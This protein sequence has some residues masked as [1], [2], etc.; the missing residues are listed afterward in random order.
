MIFGI[1][2]ATCVC[3]RK[4][5]D[6]GQLLVVNKLDQQDL[7]LNDT[8]SMGRV[9]LNL[10]VRW[11]RYRGWMPEQEQIAFSI[12]PVSVP[13]QTFA[14]RDFFVWNNF[15]PRIGLT[16]D[17][18]NDGKTVIKAS[19]GLF[20]HNPGPGVSADANPNQNN[21]SVTYTWTDR[22]GDSTTSGRGVGATRRRRRWPARSSSIRTSRRRTR[23]M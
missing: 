18:A 20:W 13:A 15:G 6:D 5:S 9:T 11:D 7:F 14:E 4:A 3:G 22:N 12:G 1:P 21:K 2:T 10:G 19:Y 17:L 16:Y 23:T 8:W